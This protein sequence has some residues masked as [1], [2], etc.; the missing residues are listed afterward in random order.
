MV[1]KDDDET[2]TQK[3]KQEV[4]SIDL[5]LK[6]LYMKTVSDKLS[7]SLIEKNVER[8][9]E[10]EDGEKDKSCARWKKMMTME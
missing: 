3:H 1:N 7:W 2:K 5:S 10:K 4:K 9:V 6:S 8:G